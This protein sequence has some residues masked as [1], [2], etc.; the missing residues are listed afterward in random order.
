MIER[1]WHRL[2]G[3]RIRRYTRGV[4]HGIYHAIGWIDQHT[5]A[6]RFRNGWKCSCDKEW[7]EL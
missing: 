4:R 5:A 2:R 3:H 1:A 7:A 6:G